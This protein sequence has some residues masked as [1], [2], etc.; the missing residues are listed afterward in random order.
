MCSDIFSGT[1]ESIDNFPRTKS[2]FF[3]SVQPKAATNDR[4]NAQYLLDLAG[5][6][7]DNS[8]VRHSAFWLSAFDVILGFTI[9]LCP[10]SLKGQRAGILRA[11]ISIGQPRG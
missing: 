1:K 7:S 3:F 5:M 11:D 9:V 8:G 2:Y 6:F 4:H 10:S